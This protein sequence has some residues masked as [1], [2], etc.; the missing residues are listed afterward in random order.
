MSCY[1]LYPN[2]EHKGN[3]Q[4]LPEPFLQGVHKEHARPIS[5]LLWQGMK[6]HKDKLKRM[7]MTEEKD[8]DK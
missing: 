1:S 4:K 8:V 5:Y 2:N 3:S 6:M 7:A